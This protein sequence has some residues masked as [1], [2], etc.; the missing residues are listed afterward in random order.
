MAKHSGDSHLGYVHLA[1][2]I[3][4]VVTPTA[5]LGKKKEEIA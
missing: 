2:W 3:L 1:I 5:V 4:R